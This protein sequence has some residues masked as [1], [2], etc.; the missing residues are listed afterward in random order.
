MR[1]PEQRLYDRWRKN[2]PIDPQ[3]MMRVENAM[4]SGMGDVYLFHPEQGVFVELK[5]S[6]RPANEKSYLV[7]PGQIR[8]A[9]RNFHRRSALQNIPT[10]FLISDEDRV[11]YVVPGI[12]MLY[13]KGVRLNLAKNF[14]AHNWEQVHRVI[15][16][17]LNPRRVEEDW[18]LARYP[19]GRITI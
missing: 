14:V 17:L 18:L 6:Q 15:D 13:D 19:E 8:N 2:A 11:L 4:Q 7:P 16:M 3:D 10:F 5:V 1:K 9:Q 12:T